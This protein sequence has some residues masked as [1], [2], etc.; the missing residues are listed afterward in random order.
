M[1]ARRPR[2][3]DGDCIVCYPASAFEVETCQKAGQDPCGLDLDAPSVKDQ[4]AHVDSR[5]IRGQEECVNSRTSGNLRA[6]PSLRLQGG[7]S[8]IS[9]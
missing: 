2:E 9:R 8:Q 6:R 5:T 7:A 4:G 1:G 3:D